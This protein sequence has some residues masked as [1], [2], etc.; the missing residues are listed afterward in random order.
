VSA[1]HTLALATVLAAQLMLCMDLLIV[2]VALPRMQAD[3]GFNPAGLT[4][5][6]NGFGLGCPRY[7]LPG[8]AR[9]AIGPRR[10]HRS[11]FCARQGGDH[12]RRGR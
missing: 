3:L 8:C 10:R 7:L 11:C 12:A 1:R 9:S 2:V 4:W 6:L 5:V